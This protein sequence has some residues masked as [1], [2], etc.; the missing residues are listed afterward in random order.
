MGMTG[1]FGP[2]YPAALIREG[3]RYTL[4]KERRW[5]RLY[6][7]W[8]GNF[9]LHISRFMDGSASITFPELA[10]EWPDWT[11]DERQDFCDACSWLESRSDFP[12]MLRF[13][14]SHGG[15]DEWSSVANNVAETLPRDEAF[16]LLTAALPLFNQ[17]RACNMI[18]GIAATRHP[19]AV[20]VLRDHLAELWA[21]PSL[22]ED[23]A[24]TNWIAD[25]AVFCIQDLIKLGV[26]PQEFEEQVHRLAAHPCGGSR[27]ACRRF[28]TQH[29]PWLNDGQFD[30]FI[31]TDD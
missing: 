21:H 14:M 24:F 16:H 28:L 6:R 8:E 25:G 22:W 10:R 20:N 2:E 31:F 15:P 13:I 26:P 19:K 4:A 3:V 11:P 5:T 7:N 9:W 29:F 30:G 17:D 18:Q 12:E 27:D 1:S 23:D